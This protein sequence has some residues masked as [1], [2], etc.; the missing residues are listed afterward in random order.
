MM[1][2]PAQSLRERKTQ[3]EKREQREFE[4]MARAVAHYLERRGWKILVV[5]DARM[6][7][8][9]GERTYNHEFVVRVT[10]VKRAST[11]PAP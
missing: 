7:H 3:N 4:A 2:K 10:G 9:P 8:Q 6:Q 11:E 1:P 5:G